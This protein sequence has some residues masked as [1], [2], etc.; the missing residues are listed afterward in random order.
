MV[1]EIHIIGL[2]IICLVSHIFG[3]IL[4]TISGAETMKEYLREFG[5]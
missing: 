4:G 5:E 2:I 1:V 3:V